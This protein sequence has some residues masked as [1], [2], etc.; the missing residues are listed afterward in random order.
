MTATFR[1]VSRRISLAQRWAQRRN[2]I[3]VLL[4]Q[5]LLWLYFF[6]RRWQP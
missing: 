5:Q 4:Y 6:L 1:E 2:A 3:I